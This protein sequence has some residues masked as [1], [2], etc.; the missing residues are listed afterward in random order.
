[1][2]SSQVSFALESMP[3]LNRYTTPQ[4]TKIVISTVMK[5]STLFSQP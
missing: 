1:M 3:L 4:M 2:T 5:G